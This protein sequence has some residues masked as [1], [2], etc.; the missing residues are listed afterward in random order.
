MTRGMVRVVVVLA[1]R[2]RHRLD[3]HVFLVLPGAQLLAF[4]PGRLVG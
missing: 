3:H 2:L 4:G 1:A